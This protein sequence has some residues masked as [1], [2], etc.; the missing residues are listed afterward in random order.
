MGPSARLERLGRRRGAGLEPRHPPQPD[1]LPPGRRP[2]EYWFDVANVGD[3]DTHGPITLKVNLPS[4]ITRKSVRLATIDGDAIQ[5]LR[6]A[7]GAAPGPSAPSS[8]TCTTTSQTIARHSLSRNVCASPSDVAPR[9]RRRA[10]AS[11]SVEGGGAAAT[12]ACANE[13]THDRSP[14][15][16]ASASSPTASCPTSSR[17]TGSPRN[18]KPAPTPTSSPSPSTSTRS[19]RRPSQRLTQKLRGREHPRPPRRPAARLRRQP[20]RGRRVHPGASSRCG[21]CP[22]LEPGGPARRSPTIPSASP[23]PRPS[24]AI[25]TGVFNLS[26][27]RGAITDLGFVVAGNP[28]HIKASLDPANHYAIRSAGLRHQRDPAALQPEADPLGRSGRPQPRLRAL[29]PGSAL[30][31]GVGNTGKECSTDARRP[32]PSSPSPRSANQTHVMRLHHYDSWQH[33]GVFGPEIDYT[34]CRTR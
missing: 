26:H 8:L 34:A 1:Q 4:G 18:A 17:P 12:G 13:P 28:V 24:S 20:D 25:T 7:N 21:N 15:R 22:R 31:A 11:A 33:T 14:N 5:Q 6:V 2:A 10:A 16:P 23:Q 19:T 30:P 9:R 32:S 29:R 3:T 27:P